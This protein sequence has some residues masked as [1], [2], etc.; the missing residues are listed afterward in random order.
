MESLVSDITN[1]RWDVVLPMTSHLQLPKDKLEDLYELV[2]LEMIEL[3]EVDTARAILRQTQIFQKM[4]VE[5]PDRFSKLDRFCNQA[6]YEVSDLYGEISRDK[7]RGRIAHSI[8]Q[9]V[10][11]VPPSRLMDLIGQ[12]LKYQQ[13]QGLI[14]TGSSFDLFKGVVQS[15]RDEV[16]TY[17]NALQTEIRVP[18]ECH[19]ECAKFT[20]DG[21][22]LV[23]GSVDG[24]IECWDFTIG[25][26]R[27]DLRYQVEENFM[28]H[29]SAVLCLNFTRDGELLA[30]GA[31]NGEM[32][33]WRLRSGQCLRK[34]NSAHSAG[35]TSV[36]FSNDGSQVLSASFDHLIKIHGLKS[37]KVLKEFRGHSSFVNCA[38]FSVDGSQVFS[39]SSDCTVRIWD[40]KRAETLML[41]TPPHNQTIEPALLSIH[42][43]PKASD[44]LILA[45]RSSTLLL[46]NI[47]GELLK[48]LQVE[49]KEANDFLSLLI[50]PRGEWYFALSEDSKIYCFS[51]ESSKIEH[52]LEVHKKGA[53]GFCHHP[54]RN[55][56]ATFNSEGETKIW[57]AS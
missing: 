54:H 7:R 42:L 16:E 5:T 57:K 33:I 19:H 4:K 30:S 8:S 15:H 46:V 47:Y 10:C 25:K 37:G 41:F 24:M 14:P 31:N 32:K 51:S 27:D 35:I 36:Q 44:Q 12:A 11:V 52:V 28:F 34:F 20:P 3:H 43:N 6:G 49:S 22:M 21:Q 9:E 38:I 23:T 1:G 18:K 45:P 17:P 26:I 56:I 13:S 39:C 2:V 53:I 29:E 50:S 40:T 55:L 48:T